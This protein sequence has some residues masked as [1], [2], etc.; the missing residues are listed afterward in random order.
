MEASTLRWILIVIGVIVIASV[1]LFGNPSKKRKPKASRRREE[2]DSEA[3][4][5]RD[6]MAVGD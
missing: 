2:P 4:V 3:P 5:E 6:A 1:W